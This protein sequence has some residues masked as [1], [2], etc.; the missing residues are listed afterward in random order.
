MTADYADLIARGLVFVLQL[1]T[2]GA[3]VG[4]VVLR[5]VERTLWIENVAVRPEYQ[6]RGLGRQMLAFAESQ[7]RAADS[8]ELRL[9]ANEVMVENIALYERLG[10]RELE[11]RIHRGFHRVFMC[12]EL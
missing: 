5:Q 3:I 12:K 7:A 10:Y 8:V 9:Y 11:R 1:D 4:V 2:D 6:H